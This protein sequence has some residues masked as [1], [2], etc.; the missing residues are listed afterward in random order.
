MRSPSRE[1]RRQRHHHHPENWTL[2]NKKKTQTEAGNYLI[3]IRHTHSIYLIDG[4]TGAIL[5]TLGGKGNTFK[6]LATPDGLPRPSASLL[7]MAWQHHARWVPGT[8]ETE[9]T[10]FDNRNKETT[11]GECTAEAG[12]CSRAL[13][14]RLDTTASP[15]TAQILREYLHPA[16]L[17]AQ[18]QG[19]VQP[20][21]GDGNGGFDRVF[22]GW[23]RCPTFTEHDAAT[24]E[25][26]LDVQFSPWHSEEVPDALDNYRAFRQDWVGMPWWNPAVQLRDGEGGTLEVYVSWNGATEV[27]EWVVKG[28]VG[29]QLR[30]R[31][32][33]D[34]DEGGGD[35]SESLEVMARSRRT[36]FETMM[37]V[38]P[39]GLRY[40][41]VEALDAQGKILGRTEILDFEKAN[42][43][44]L[45]YESQGGPVVTVLKR[46][47]PLLAG[48]A[49]GIVL[50]V[51]GGRVF[52]QR[53]ARDYNPLEAEDFDDEVGS[54]LDIESV[55]ELDLF[56]DDAG[57]E[58]WRDYS[59]KLAVR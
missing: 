39:F 57:H 10:V 12:T 41:W 58:A 52:W 51:M 26:L 40:L 14:V 29:R 47:W 3:S 38:S 56:D 44:I 15:P 9:M 42:V 32:D 36:G 37:T 2:T 28:L 31:M 19:S 13:H 25:V 17:Q 45:P 1:R 34:E 43:T 6:E 50:F 53:C 16:R 20:L 59:P 11:H 46:K 35:M 7:S 49:A 4:K 54:D 21:G 33:D 18:S 55:L 5:W 23:G 48:V 27:R 30:V 24:G 8:G 22:I